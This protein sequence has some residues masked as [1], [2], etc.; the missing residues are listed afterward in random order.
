VK[1]RS[2]L[3]FRNPR[4]PMKTLSNLLLSSGLNTPHPSRLR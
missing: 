3:F 2:R 4:F 1:K